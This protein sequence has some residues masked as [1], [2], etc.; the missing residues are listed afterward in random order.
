MTKTEKIYEDVFNILS[1]NYE[2]ELDDNG[3]ATYTFDDDDR[4]NIVNEM[5]AYILSLK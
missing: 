4:D 5:T 1:S 2:Q 3:E